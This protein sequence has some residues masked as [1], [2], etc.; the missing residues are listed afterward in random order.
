[1]SRSGSAAPATVVVV[2]REQFS[3]API[4]LESVLAS[5]SVPLVYVDGNSPAAVQHYLQQTAQ[6]RSFKLIRANHYLAANQ[7]RNLAIPYID[8][9]YAVF[10]DNDVVPWP[11]WLEA[12]VQCAEETGAWAVGP[13]YCVGDGSDPSVPVVHQAGADC[14]ISTIQGVA[15]F[16]ERH[17]PACG[18]PLAEVRQQLTRRPCEL[19]E[20][21]CLLV[22]M[23]AVHRF[24]GLDEGL[25]SFFDHNDFCLKARMVGG[26]LAIE[27]DAVVTYLPPPPFARSD[28]AYFLLRWSQTWF[29]A[30]LRHF[31]HTWG[32]DIQDPSFRDHIAYRIAH[33]RRA[34][35]WWSTR[36]PGP[37]SSA[38]DLLVEGTIGSLLERT[39]VR[40]LDQARRSGHSR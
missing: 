32:L 9:T 24:G 12:L 33:R 18:K 15:R 28:L 27:P 38:A 6:Q 22:R 1:V 11:G 34:Y 5:T 19:L 16:V 4:S 37:R 29:S 23:D 20:F 35:T 36:P 40:R 7:A 14:H 39:L 13:L 2:P 17:S 3:K 10:L 25:L 31:C 8:T 26:E 21:H 30:S